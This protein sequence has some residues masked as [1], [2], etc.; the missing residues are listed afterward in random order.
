MDTIGSPRLTEV[1]GFAGVDAALVDMMFCPTDW[2]TIAAMVRAGQHFDMDVLVRIPGYPWFDRTDHHMAADAVRALGC[3]ASG[4]MTSCATVEEVEQLVAVSKDWHR[5]I[6]LHPFGDD[7]FAEYAK[8]V[9]AECLVMPL[10]ESASA[11]EN[12]EGILAIP[13]LRAVSL[14]MTD[15]SRML[16]HDFEYEHPDVRKFTASV[17]EAGREH[18]VLVG[19]NVGY[20]FS[21]SVSETRAR[22]DTLTAE[23]FDFLWLQNNG[24]VIQWL[25]RSLLGVASETPS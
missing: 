17:I 24:F 20:Q 2:S 23:G 4:V 25:Y 7:E 22:I 12:I 14:G 5:D 10:I 9:S 15:I 16:G 13:G 8:T 1:M 19:A 3:G 11:I 18:G 6:H 21:R